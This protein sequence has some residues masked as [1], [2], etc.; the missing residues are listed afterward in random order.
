MGLEID[1]NCI[2]CKLNALEAILHNFGNVK[3]WTKMDLGANHF[4]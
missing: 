2:S 1:A 3:G 4:M